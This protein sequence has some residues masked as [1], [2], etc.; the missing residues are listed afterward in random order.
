MPNKVPLVKEELKY[1]PINEWDESDRPREKLLNS[2]AENLSDAELLAI[3]LATGYKN[4]S[5]LDLA[6]QLL[7]RFDND[8]EKF[9]TAPPEELMKLKGVGAAKA[10]TIKAAYSLCK[11]VVFT[12]FNDKIQINSTS[13]ILRKYIPKLMDLKVEHFYAI[14]LNTANQIIKETK[15][16]EGILNAS[17]VHPREVFKDAILNSAAKIIIIH[18]HPSGNPSPSI[19]DKEITKQLQDAGKIIGIDI[20]DHIIIAGNRHISFA[21][22]G[23]I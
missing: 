23:L 7:S 6:K 16:S 2:S 10:I 14:Y 8:L 13:T 1:I 22:K 20:L 11:R 3:L 15:V 18:N 5:A 12:G 19:Q 4:L 21:E 17:L 9:L